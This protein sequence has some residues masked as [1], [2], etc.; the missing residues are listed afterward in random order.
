MTRSGLGDDGEVAGSTTKTT[1][2][3]IHTAALPL[4]ADRGFG[5]IT[6]LDIAGAAGIS[7]RS[8]YRYFAD[9]E[10]V[11]F[12]YHERES[13]ILDDLLAGAPV[14]G[15][16]DVLRAFGAALTADPEMLAMRAQVVMS[17]PHLIGRAL[18]RRTD[19]ERRVAEWLARGAGASEP[20]L[21]MKVAS[22]A[23]M[24]GLY[25]AVRESVARSLPLEATLEPTLSL[26]AP[27]LAVSSPAGVHR[28][29]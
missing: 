28:P 15:L 24:G 17:T 21:E 4:F 3:A 13:V 25:V 16:A 2:T 26:L 10:A 7:R 27:A 8:L 23:G 19:W 29:A 20:T 1:K 11:F 5:T 14:G 12:E 18:V 9:K 6:M 22:S